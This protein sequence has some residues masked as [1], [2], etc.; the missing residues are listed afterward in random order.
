MKISLLVLRCKNIELCREFYE[1]IGLSFKKEKHGTGPEH[2]ASDNDGFVLELYPKGNAKGFD[3]TRLGFRVDDLNEV[4]K[5]LEIVS[6]YEFLGN[7]IYVV[8]DPD[9]RKVEL[10]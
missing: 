6:S 9:G 2:Y 1:S 5:Q 3:N 8:L 10:S 7:I 4:I